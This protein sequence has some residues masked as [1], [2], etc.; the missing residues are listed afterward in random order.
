M[1][2]FYMNTCTFLCEDIKELITYRNIFFAIIALL[3]FYIIYLAYSR[4]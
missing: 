3:I 4:K 1:N 2:D